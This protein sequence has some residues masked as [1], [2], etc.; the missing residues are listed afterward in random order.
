M[1]IALLYALAILGLAVVCLVRFERAS[2][3][4][5]RIATGIAAMLTG[6]LGLV[7]LAVV[8]FA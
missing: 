2:T 6:V 4:T 8:A 1:I 3:I 7:L 5:G